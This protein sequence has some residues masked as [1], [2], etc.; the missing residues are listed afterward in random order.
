MSIKI[1]PYKKLNKVLFK[2]R[3]G[4]RSGAQRQLI[5]GKSKINEVEA[6]KF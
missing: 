4:T 6:I 5:R 3:L 2:F 1:E